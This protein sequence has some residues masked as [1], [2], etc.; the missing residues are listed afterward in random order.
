MHSNREKKIIKIKRN[1]EPDLIK[2][3]DMHVMR[4]DSQE[5]GY[6][7][8]IIRIIGMRGDEFIYDLLEIDEKLMPI[9]KIL[10]ERK[11]AV[12]KELFSYKN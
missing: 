10:I 1:V 12:P 11:A 7:K 4:A 6:L 3:F 2:I 9:N 5:P 8:R